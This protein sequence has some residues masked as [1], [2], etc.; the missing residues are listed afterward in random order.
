MAST[1]HKDGDEWGMVY[2]CYT[3]IMDFKCF[4]EG[5]NY[6]PVE[7]FLKR[8]GLWGDFW[9][10]VFIDSKNTNLASM[11]FTHHYLL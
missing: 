6:P 8:W 3:H 10:C 11:V 9:L 5:S 7:I 4:F 1:T 2:S